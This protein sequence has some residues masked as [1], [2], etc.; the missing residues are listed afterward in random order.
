MQ[1]KSIRKSLR[2][3][4]NIA[5]YLLPK[6]IN[7]SIG[8]YTL[9]LIA[10]YLGA[11]EFGKLSYVL[12]VVSIITPIASLGVDNVLVREFVVN[13][14]K[15]EVFFSA[16]LLRL[17]FSIV[18]FILFCIYFLLYDYNNYI[19]IAIVVSF[20]IIFEAV[21]IGRFYLQAIQAPKLSEGAET[22]SLLIT[23]LLRV[24]GVLIKK[25][26]LYFASLYSIQKIALFILTLIFIFFFK[27]MNIK[28]LRFSF[29]LTKKI[30]SSAV[31]LILS[32]I[33]MII[34]L[35]VDLIMVKH[36]LGEK[37][38]GIYTVS[39]RFIEIWYLI[40][41]A[42]IS[43][44][45]PRILNYKQQDKNM[46]MAKV[47]GYYSVI[48]LLSYAVV[49]INLFILPYIITTLFS[50]EYKQSVAVLNILSFAIIFTT[51]GMLWA[52]WL[53]AENLEKY[54]FL[55]NTFGTI[56]NIILNFF[57]ISIY[58]IEG[59]AISTL[60]SS[61]VANY[62]SH[63]LVKETRVSFIHQTMGF[64]LINLRGFIWKK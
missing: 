31:F 12:A 35:K 25:D 64:L 41:H 10:N 62:V 63:I 16:F 30:L 13:V 27:K 40:F 7:I 22:L 6:L 9:I 42:F 46:F 48:A 18:A 28:G 49:A 17:I 51:S 53:I 2:D 43:F 54:G 26:T 1:K 36:M 45:F 19:L 4:E 57:L 55:F 8:T 32:H 23:N 11:Y 3:F 29:P 21:N 20:S 60:I 58:G 50:Y 56:I 14:H 15:G 39:T 5:W 33:S 44:I 34:Y 38:V 24:I 52:R 59:A 47:Q 61:I 37:F